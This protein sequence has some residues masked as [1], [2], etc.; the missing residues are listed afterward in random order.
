[1]QRQVIEYG[2]IPV[3]IAVPHNGRLRFIA[4]KFHVIDLDNQQFT[5]VGEL[6]AA[7]RDHLN[8]QPAMAA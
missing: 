2:G 5:S 7:I 1:M 6:K 8:S 3:G 4:V